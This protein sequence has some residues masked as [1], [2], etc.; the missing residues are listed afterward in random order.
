[1]SDD[2]ARVGS[3]KR[4]IVEE[5]VT[6]IGREQEQAAAA[7]EARAAAARSADEQTTAKLRDLLTRAI[8][9]ELPTD[10]GDTP[11]LDPHV[12]KMA[13]ELMVCHLPEWRNPAGRKVAEPTT[14]HIPQ[15]V[16]LAV[17]LVAE[18]GW[19]HDPA[20][21]RRRWMP[22]P[23]GPPPAHDEGMFVE[24]DEHGRWP[25]PDP[26][27]F[28]DMSD[29]AVVQQDSGE[30]QASHPRGVGFSAASKSEAYAGIV[31]RLRAK[32]EEAK[33]GMAR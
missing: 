16:R 22:T 29:I 5:I 14:L 10:L 31:E 32:I 15:A 6:P 20:R 7:A 8:N 24:R 25:A 12:E 1:M 4:R 9:G 19:V 21:E 28:Y 23:G 13:R 33:R 2:E 11:P 27:D 26:E 3:P 18:R 30:W 17:W